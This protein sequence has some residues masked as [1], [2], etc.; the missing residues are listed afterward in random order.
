MTL[1]QIRSLIEVVERGLNVSAAA[2]GLFLSQSA[3]STQLHNLE[4]ELGGPIFVRDGKKFVGLTP[5]GRDAFEMARL[6]LT[7]VEKLKQVRDEH[8]NQNAGSLT[9]G[10]TFTQ[11]HYALPAIIQRFTREF[12][13]VLVNVRQGSPREM[14]TLARNAEVD[15]CIG[16]EAATDYPEL[17]SFPCHRWNRGVIVLPDHPLLARQPFT[18]A[19]LAQYRLVTYGPAVDTYSVVQHAFY[20][21]GLAPNIVVTAADPS[22][23]KQYVKMGLGVGIIGSAA[24]NDGEDADIRFLD[25]SHLFA[26]GTFCVALRRDTYLRGFAFRFIELYAP[27]WT[28]D[29]LSVALSGVTPS[30]APSKRIDTS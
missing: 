3:V 17:I 30:D 8:Y 23:I 1:Q 22:T 27:Q 7:H 19:D 26:S 20:T 4:G 5:M 11:A 28:R 29:A 18:L 16:T 14:L 10:A 9:V 13:Q 12:P 21:E 24:Y 15:F 6:V 2:R 25:A